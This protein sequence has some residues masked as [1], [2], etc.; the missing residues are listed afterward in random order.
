LIVTNFRQQRFYWVITVSATGTILQVGNG[1]T[2]GISAPVHHQ[3]QRRRLQ[4]KQHQHGQHNFFETGVV[5]NKAEESSSSAATFPGRLKIDVATNTTLRPPVATAL[6]RN[7]ET[8]LIEKGALSMSMD[9][10]LDPNQLPF[11]ASESGTNGAIINSGAAQI[12]ALQSVILQDNTTFGG[13]TAGIFV[14]HCF[15]S[16]HRWAAF[17]HHQSW[18]KSGFTGFNHERRRCPR[19]HR[20]PARHFCFRQINYGQVGDPAKTITVRTNATLNLFNLN[21]FR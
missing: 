2:G 14:P 9:R 4:Q 5:T 18:H 8:T 15:L 12:S 21:L 16:R 3:P 1:G 7:V 11:L 10:I 17:Q 20:H 19:R 6:G 13:S